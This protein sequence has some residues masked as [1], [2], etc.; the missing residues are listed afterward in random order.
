MRIL[1][2]KLFNKNIS[3]HKRSF[4]SI[5]ENL[6]VSMFRRSFFWI[7]A[8]NLML[9]FGAGLASINRPLWFDEVYT[10]YV[11]S[12]DD[13]YSVI[14]AILH[15][16][17]Y[18]PPLDHLIRHGSLYA[19]GQSSIAFRFPSIIFFLIASLCL[20]KFV[21]TRT[22]VTPALVAF[23]FPVLT[24]TLR[25]SHEGRAYSLL[26]ASACLSILAWQKAT[27]NPRSK[28]N[29]ILL[30]IALAL[31]PYCH[32]YGVLNYVP[33]FVGE[34]F[35]S[36]KKRRLCPHVSAAVALSLLSLICLY[37][38][39][40][41]PE[42]YLNA[43]WSPVGIIG[44]VRIYKALFPNMIYPLLASIVLVACLLIFNRQDEEKIKQR[45]RIPIH[46]F[47]AGL[48]FCLTPFTLYVIAKLFTGAMTARYALVT[49]AGFAILAGFVCQYIYERRKVWVA[50]ILLC[51][52]TSVFFTLGN[53]LVL[54]YRNQKVYFNDRLISLIQESSL[55]IIISNSHKYLELYHYLPDNIKLKPQYLIDRELAIRYLGFDTDQIDL[56]NFSAFVPLNLSLFKEFR[57]S[58]KEFLVFGETGWLIKK[59]VDDVNNGVATLDVLEVIGAHKVFHVKMQS[60]IATD[61]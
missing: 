49:I 24:L 37:P 22:S 15:K 53:D 18:Y 48:T 2:K 44:T 20:Y 8:I 19:F 56:V 31:G 47:A 23:C 54:R 60:Q 29:L 4:L 40:I 52:I 46:E 43:Y 51:F 45:A 13:C 39:V 58:A 59:I 32:F 35:R 21:K 14:Y 41:P 42:G 3:Q 28:S 25:Y 33:I 6:L 27:I 1:K 61:N 12:L 57:H 34:I 10:Y 16:A 9:V 11:S 5:S 50:A 17:D 55:P 7:A 30:S 36:I 26:F 38:F